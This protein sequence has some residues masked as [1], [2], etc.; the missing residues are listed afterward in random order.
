MLIM[1]NEK[2]KNVPKCFESVYHINFDLHVPDI[3]VN[4]PT[5][6]IIAPVKMVRL[7][8]HEAQCVLFIEVF[9]FFSEIKYLA[10]V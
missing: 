10:A 2:C 8:S 7:T 1:L 3:L 5:G 9:H 6:T 4:T